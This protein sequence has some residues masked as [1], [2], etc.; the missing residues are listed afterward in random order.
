MLGLM[1]LYRGAW[2]P[3]IGPVKPFC[4]GP[5]GPY[6]GVILPY[7]IGPTGPIIV[8]VIGAWGPYNR[9]YLQ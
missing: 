1:A 2:G 6:T 9:G 5:W 7:I 3:S 8:T 4:I